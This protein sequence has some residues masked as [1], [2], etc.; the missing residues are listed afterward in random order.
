MDIKQRGAANYG[1]SLPITPT[2]IEISVQ[3][4]IDKDLE[5]VRNI[6]PDNL[7][8]LSDPLSDTKLTVATRKRNDKDAKTVN[9]GTV[10]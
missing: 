7:E 3:P 4:G 1:I 5:D 2:K 9:N 10:N 6:L 8:T